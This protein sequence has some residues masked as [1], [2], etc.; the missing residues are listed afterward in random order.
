[1]VPSLVVA[2]ALFFGGPGS[3]L[4]ILIIGLLLM[5]VRFAEVFL[6]TY[7][8][9][10]APAGTKVGG[11]M[12]YLGAVAGGKI[13]PYLYSV[14]C[15]AYGLVVANAMQVNSIAISLEKA[16]GVSTYIIGAV[17]LVFVIYIMMGGAQR[18]V[19][20][21]EKL[22]PSRLVYFVFQHLLF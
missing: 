12:L 19:S 18:I 11:P 17:L 14:V 20:A 15:L 3:V 13:L 7:F 16:V 4:W 1:M 8:A 2:T 6:S 22:V 9:A 21:S 10:R 5:A